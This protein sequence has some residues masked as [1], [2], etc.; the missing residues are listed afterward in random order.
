MENPS[1]LAK[2]ISNYELAL[3]LEDF[4]SLSLNLKNEWMNLNA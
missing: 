4:L 3:I 2:Y 1:S